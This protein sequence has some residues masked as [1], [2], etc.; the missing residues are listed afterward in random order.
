MEA[1]TEAVLDHVAI[2]VADRAAAEQELLDRFDIRVFERTDR[3]TLLGA[4]PKFGKITLLDEEGTEESTT[5]RVVSLVLAGSSD[6]DAVPVTLSSGFVV[7]FAE[8]DGAEPAPPRHALVG[9]SLRSSDPPIAAA[10][11]EAVGDLHVESVGLEHAVLDV[12]SSSG[13]GRITL[14]RERGGDHRS[15]AL[16]HIGLR[17]GDARSWRDRFEAHDVDVVRWVDAAHSRAVFVD[18]PDDVLVE[19]VEQTAPFE[20]A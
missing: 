10:Q 1:G 12:G 7:T 15:S 2:R 4:D 9:I 19:F 18:G 5:D 8:H 13:G 20:Q 14:L 11:Y 17:V 16:D 6:A 3:L